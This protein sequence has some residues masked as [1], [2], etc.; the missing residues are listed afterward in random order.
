MQGLG[1][2]T[3]LIGGLLIAAGAVISVAMGVTRVSRLNLW[4]IATA[5]YVTGA[6]LV[7][8]PHEKR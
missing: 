4:L 8:M 1:L 7:A 5:L 6:L 2:H 3:G